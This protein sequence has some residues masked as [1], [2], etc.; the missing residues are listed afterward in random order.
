[1]KKENSRVVVGAMMLMG[2]ALVAG[3]AAFG[4]DPTPPSKFEQAHFDIVT[5]VQPV[6]VIRTNTVTVTNTVIETLTVTNSLNQTVVLFQ[7]NLVPQVITVLATNTVE[8]ETYTYKPNT[9]AAALTAGAASLGQFS[10]VPGIGT[11]ISIGGTALWGLWGTLRSS[12]RG[13]ALAVA[14]QS[15][16]TM[17][18]VLAKTPQGQRVSEEMQAWLDQHHEVAGAATIINS[19]VDKY[20]DDGAARDAA[21]QILALASAPP[22]PVN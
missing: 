9:N 12:G 15:V 14:S 4:S 1:M 13:K 6:I 22:R 10:G 5:N 21:H 20:V 3:C 18:Q 7:T 16:A 17:Q 19:F 2:L 11:L 8:H